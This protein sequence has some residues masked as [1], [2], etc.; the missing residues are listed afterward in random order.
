MNEV[1]PFMALIKE[2]SFIF[3]IHLPKPE[4]F[5][6]VFE[7]NQSFISI[8]ESNIFSPKTKHI[9]IKY[10]HFQSFIQKN[11]IRM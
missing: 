8:V 11:V 1:I 4:V 5:C 7:E 3:D 10:H 6:K 2:A 9:A